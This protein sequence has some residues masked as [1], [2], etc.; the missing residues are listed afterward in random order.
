MGNRRRIRNKKYKQEQQRRRASISQSEVVTTP[1]TVVLPPQVNDGDYYP[2]VTRSGG[3]AVEIANIIS[4]GKWRMIF[5]GWRMNH[6]LR[7]IHAVV[8]RR[9]T[10]SDV[11]CIALLSKMDFDPMGEHFHPWCIDLIFTPEC[12][13]RRG[14]ASILAKI[15]KLGYEVSAH[16]NS[17]ESVK[18]FK[19]AGYKQHPVMDGLMRSC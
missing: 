3:E 7:C 18:M 17:D 10:D 13:R 6:P 4:Y 2:F 19:K 9:N 15:L 5:D 14:Y 16:C 8:L 12:H 1:S 11:K